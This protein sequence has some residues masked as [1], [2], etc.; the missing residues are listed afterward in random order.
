MDIVETLSRINRWW[1]TGKVDKNFL[2]PAVRR[3]FQRII[4]LLGQDRILSI[5]GP[6]RSGKSVLLTNT[7]DYL[8]KQGVH[9]QRILFLS[10]DDPALFAGI[11]SMGDVLEKYANDVIH[12]SFNELT[13]KIYIL[14][15]EVHALPDW[16]VWLKSYYDR[17][18]SIKFIVSG[19]S[20]THLFQ[21]S[22]ESLLGRI[23]SIPIL[24]LSFRQFCYFWSVYKHEP[25]LIEF[26]QLLP[27]G[28][29]F[30][31]PAKYYH[32]LDQ[33]R[34]KWEPFKPLISGILKE[35]LLVGGYPEYFTTPN[36]AL[37]Q[38]RLIDDIIGQGLYRDIINV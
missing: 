27:D 28:N 11:V 37:W 19:S 8:L 18:L 9:P 29:V 5:I 25:R 32:M 26:I 2:Y 12:E 33:N 10:G 34:W 22:K 7:I 23:E 35:Y 21:G 14:I 13:S 30:S 24:P 17:R 36:I 38:K 31:D 3:E 6:R 15:D 20:S 16:Q 4:T 1:G